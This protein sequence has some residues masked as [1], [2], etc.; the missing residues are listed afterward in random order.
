VR[1]RR[2]RR[3]SGRRKQSITTA[4]L[5]G[6]TRTRKAPAPYPFP[7]PSQQL[8]RSQGE[9]ARRTP[10]AEQGKT[11]A[12]ANAEPSANAVKGLIPQCTH[13]RST[14]KPLAIARKGSVAR[15]R[16]CAAALCRPH[17]ARVSMVP[18]AL[19]FMSRRRRQQGGQKEKEEKG[20]APSHRH[21]H[22]CP[23]P[24]PPP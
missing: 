22:P 20:N 2:R 17:H 6:R 18:L 19:E 10:R 21:R 8:A 13:G 24:S 3:R 4:T 7:S 11:K 1:R 9:N 12:S 5:L 16:T 14:T 15:T 23:P